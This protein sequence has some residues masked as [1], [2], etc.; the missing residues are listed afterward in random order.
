VGKLW[1][2]FMVQMCTSRYTFSNGYSPF[3]EKH[4]FALW[5]ILKTQQRK[6]QRMY[7]RVA[8]QSGQPSTWQWKSTPLS[9]LH[10][11]FHWLQYY[12]AFPPDRLRIFSSSSREAMNEQLVRENQGL[13]S[14]S[15]TVTHF[16]HERRLCSPRVSGGIAVP[17]PQGYQQT[18]SITVSSGTRWNES[19]ATPAPDGRSRSSLEMRRLELELGTGADHNVPYSF[20]LSASMPQVLAWIRLL[21]KVQRGEIQP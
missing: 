7:Y 15:V 13:G 12:R 14:A 8:I 9:S 20:A 17:T 6:R 11:L 3:M 10:A 5:N 16:L 2:L 19:S 4:S 21:V 1:V 18:A